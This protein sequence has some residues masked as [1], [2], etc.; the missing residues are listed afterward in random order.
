MIRGAYTKIDLNMIKNIS[1]YHI[2]KELYAN[3]TI[4]VCRGID[5][6]SNQSVIIKYLKKEYPDLKDIK[7]IRKE[8]DLIKDLN[9]EGTV[10]PIELKEIGQTIA[11]IF[12]DFGGEGLNSFLEKYRITKK[13]MPIQ[14]ILQIGM[15]ISE[16]LYKI[17]ASN[18]IHRDIKPSNIMY[19]SQTHEI[20]ITD[21]GIA[22]PEKEITKRQNY[23]EGSLAY[24]SPEQTGKT[25]MIMDYR[26][27]IYSLGVTLYELS[28]NQL[29]FD[30]ED[31]NELVHAHIAKIPISPEYLNKNLPSILGKIILKCLRK[32]PDDRY[33][34]SLGLKYDLEILLKQLADKNQPISLSNMNFEL[35]SK[36]IPMR[37]K[38]PKKLYGREKNISQIKDF[39]NE[40]EQQKNTHLLL[41]K[42]PSGIGKSSLIQETKNL[43]QKK[44]GY[45]LNGKFEEFTKKTGYT[46]FIQM[47]ND[48]IRHILSLD[49]IE[50][51][52]ISEIINKSI[53]PN[54]KVLLEIAPDLEL[55]IG[56]QNPI[57]KLSA[58]ESENRLQFTL[59]KFLTSLIIL[60]KPLVIF[61]DD[62]HWADSAS[63]NLIQ[64]LINN[65]KIHHLL[66]IGAYRDNEITKNHPL[67][68]L[69]NQLNKENAFVKIISPNPLSEEHV[70]SYIQEVLVSKK[71]KMNDL[72][73]Y[74]YKLT[75]G[76][77]LFVREVLRRLYDE[78]FIFFN[79]KEHLW[80]W[81]LNKIESLQLSSDVLD[82]LIKKIQKLSFQTQE[83]LKLA[84]CIGTE[85]TSALLNQITNDTPTLEEENLKKIDDILQE[86]IVEDILLVFKEN[87]YKFLHDKVQ[88]AV[89]SL[90]SEEEKKKYHL[91]IGRTYL[92]ITPKRKIEEQL[93]KIVNQLNFSA[94]CIH[95]T[96]EKK[97][98]ILY[99]LR[100][101]RRA[102]LSG[103]Y[104]QALTHI[105]TGIKLFSDNP[106]QNQYELT[107]DYYL[108]LAECEY[109][110]ANFDQAEDL[111]QFLLKQISQ[112]EE[113]IKIYKLMIVLYANM[114]QIK[115]AVDVALEGLKLFNIHFHS[116][117]SKFKILIEII[118]TRILQ[119]FK[120]SQ[121]LDQLPLIKNEN[122]KL[123]TEL[124]R[125]MFVPT[126]FVD[127][128]LFAFLSQKSMQITLKYGN[129]SISPSSFGSNSI[130]YTAFL[131]KYKLGKL[132]GDLLRKTLSLAPDPWSLMS[133]YGLS[134]HHWNYPLAEANQWIKEGFELSLNQ[135]ELL[136]SSIAAG[137]LAINRIL[138]G[139]VMENIK[140]ELIQLL[141]HTR[142]AKHNRMEYSILSIQ[143][144]ILALQG[145]TSDPT[146]IS[147]KDLSEDSL[148]NFFKKNESGI[149]LHWFYILKLRL[150]IIFEKAQKGYD[151]AQE[152]ESIKECALPLFTYKE[153]H[154]LNAMIAVQK[155]EITERKSEKKKALRIFKTCEKQL[156]TW[157]AH[158][159]INVQHKYELLQA[160]EAQIQGEIQKAFYLYEQ[161]IDHASQ[162][163]FLQDAALSSERAGLLAIK[164]N[165]KRLAKT[166]IEESIYFYL[167]W[168]AT[169]KIEQMK[170]KYSEILSLELN[171]M[172]HSI[173]IKGNR[174]LS[175]GT[176]KTKTSTSLTT[177]NL[178]D[179]ASVIKS[180]QAIASEI[181]FDKLLHR[182]MQNIIENSGAQKGFF[183]TQETKDQYFINA[184]YDSTQNQFE[185]Y[186]PNQKCINSTI[187]ATSLIY[188]ANQKKESV[189]Y[190]SSL[191]NHQFEIDPYITQ[192]KPK[193]ILCLPVFYQ[194]KI[195]GFIYLEN[196]LTSNAFT[197]ES[198]EVIK[199]LA[200]QAAIAFENAKLYQNL[201]DLNQNLEHKVQEKTKD[202]QL[203]NMNL[204]KANEEAQIAKKEAESANQFKSQ[205]L[206]RMS[207]DLRTPLHVIIGTLDMLLNH[208]KLNPLISKSLNI[209]LKSGERQLT[210][211]NDIL[212][213]SKLESGK[214]EMNY[215]LF[216]HTELF[217][218][219]DLT[220]KALL[221]DKPVKFHIQSKIPVQTQLYSDKNRL[222]QIMTNLLSNAAKF[223]LKGSITLKAELQKNQK[224]IAFEIIDTGIGLKEKDIKRA[225][226]VYTT[227]DNELQ[228]SI[229]GTGLGLPI[230]K[231]LIELLHG[232]IN[233]NSTYQKGTTVRFWLPNKIEKEITKGHRY[234]TTSPANLSEIFKEKQILLCD[235][236][237]FNRMYVQMILERKISYQLASNGRQAIEYMTKKKFD[238]V[239]MDIQMP[240]MDGKET[241]K[242]IREFDTTTP[243]IALTAQAMKGDKEELLALG[244]KDYLA[245][246]FKEE[247]FLNFLIEKLK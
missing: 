124:I 142:R 39:L 152:Y 244:F 62:L 81:K 40:M 79:E 135:G 167:K 145:E 11:I 241:L 243:I 158:N 112:K 92:K 42:G 102:K 53:T 198:I 205:F 191:P 27:D 119:L 184:L 83:L 68:I 90:I 204:Q 6:K 13:N 28:T 110:L 164:H 188:Y 144:F 238:M 52:H 93:F 31:A 217:E 193:S 33:Q 201:I 10:K 129:S 35:G 96:K 182:L 220:M 123:Y 189:E 67:Q 84:S 151:F 60:G 227:I 73:S 177:S 126:F 181:Q 235:D 207:H 108:E 63:L 117:P 148:L 98:L 101:A 80:D 47:F 100:A 138:A 192:H 114:G 140:D 94:D 239:F 70:Q 78:Q 212:D 141:Q 120:D 65:S 137:N 37:L 230:C 247:E 156:K 226:E 50:R 121:K 9:I 213:L 197:D 146:T 106:W 89:Y 245:K 56:K 57:H 196:N 208:Q 171:F 154:F 246:P 210:L 34:N 168:G 36:D 24:I 76:N 161:A 66:L 21:F 218:G 12:E 51:N 147:N 43:I 133:L 5:E 15:Q 149:P 7:K 169:A 29:P 206:A 16:I 55:I 150:F 231:Q 143:G 187:L 18:I 87:T 4:S 49:Q 242:Q 97:A 203:A 107:K 219:L 155:Y 228:K 130:V 103:A 176:S 160:E 134:I 163:N 211:V 223:T 221:K 91:S 3:A 8:F 1:G 162:Q 54:G 209:A 225:F 125:I 229:K 104:E 132:Y 236:D 202:L 131:K 157:N 2:Q 190:S 14:E 61:L 46:A 173:S 77:P 69:L 214:I 88:Q 26:S 183:I 72:C 44:N 109:L 118:H 166:F 232:E 127:K 74:I 95:N 113:K 178:L 82:I 195:D 165:Q 234:K 216:N 215:T 38:L 85:F 172:D 194:T 237:E 71:S 136:F 32:S 23:L 240:L 86:A 180:A 20:K 64:Y 159:G 199:I 58:K 105:K 139:D 175:I 128:N 170:S 222:I 48:L 45:F 25:N 233:I 122:I 185:I 224:I 111:F 75:K 30:F 153:H 59:G 200:S 174:T 186:K 99:N 115:K 116:N 17:H 19:N 179:F 22:I 41:I